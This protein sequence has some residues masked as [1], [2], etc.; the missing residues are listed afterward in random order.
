MKESDL[1]DK[2]NEFYQ[3]E[4]MIYKNEIRMGIGIPD[5]LLTYK[6]IEQLKIITDY[7]ELEL[8]Y[9]LIRSNIRRLDTLL[10]KYGY[11]KE[12]TKKY[13]NILTKKDI[14]EIINEKIFIKNRV[15]KEKLGNIISIE[16][17]LKDWK[18]ALIQA[19]RYL[20]FSD[21]SYVALPNSTVERINKEIFKSK[22]IGILVVEDGVKEVIKAKK[23]KKCN[24]ILKY[25]AASHLNIDR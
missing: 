18:S 6:K 20:V 14:I 12:H 15:D 16:A 24:D 2:I 22:G 7:Y 5:V 23:S 13:L 21:Y 10:N 3:K 9:F 1:V 17:K 11:S 25:I 8:Y 4:G 19:E